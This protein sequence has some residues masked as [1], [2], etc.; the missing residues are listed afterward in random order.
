[1][2]YNGIYNDKIC[3]MQQSIFN[4][5]RNVCSKKNESLKIEQ[6]TPEYFKWYKITELPHPEYRPEGSLEL[7]T[8]Y[9]VTFIPGYKKKKRGYYYGVGWI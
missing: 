5:E 7:R 1:M 8:P 2:Q 6:F 4:S 3:N 9:E